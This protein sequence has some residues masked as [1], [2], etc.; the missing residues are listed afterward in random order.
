[1]EEYMLSRLGVEIASVGTII[2]FC[3]AFCIIMFFA[4]IGIRNVRV[5]KMWKKYNLHDQRILLRNGKRYQGKFVGSKTL[6][7]ESDKKYKAQ[8]GFVEYVDENGKTWT[9]R[10]STFTKD[11]DSGNVKKLKRMKSIPILAYKNLC[12]FDIGLDPTDA[13][14]TIFIDPLGFGI[15]KEFAKAFMLPKPPKYHPKDEY[16]LQDD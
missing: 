1:M 8:I 6:P 13:E 7:I 12:H 5:K 16:P 10:T 2:A 4:Y 9:A 15:A 3:A 11:I 14:S